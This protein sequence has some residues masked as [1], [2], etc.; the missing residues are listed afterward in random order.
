MKKLYAPFT[1][2][3]YVLYFFINSLI[4][5][6]QE[7]ISLICNPEGWT[8]R[9]GGSKPKWTFAFARMEKTF[10]NSPHIR[11]EMNHTEF[12]CCVECFLVYINE[13]L[14]TTKPKQK[15]HKQTNKRLSSNGFLWTA[16]RF[17]PQTTSFIAEGTLY[18][19][20]NFFFPKLFHVFPPYFLLLGTTS[21]QIILAN[22]YDLTALV[23]FNDQK[24][25]SV[26]KCL[27]TRFTSRQT[28]PFSPGK[29]KL[30][31]WVAF[32]FLQTVMDMT[33]VLLQKN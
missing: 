8:A 19:P 14:T 13:K 31:S 21:F 2:A 18:F 32:F 20:D 10:R 25:A 16:T 30:H 17:T 1:L 29:E 11:K 24:E 26:G 27:L 3:S 7:T 5:Y 6:M 9:W 4:L 15:P 12:C 22:N 28:L 23:G 33:T